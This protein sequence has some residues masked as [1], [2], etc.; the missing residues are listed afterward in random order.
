M[1]VLNIRNLSDDVHQRLRERA[2]RHQRSMEAEART[3]LT[4]V[5]LTERR[6]SPSME[7][8]RELIDTFYG[9]QKPTGVVD[10]FLAER[11]REAE[12]EWERE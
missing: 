7:H 1:A 9:D 2:E 8:V 4:D 11:R 10:E 3:I 6:S 12:R 5:L